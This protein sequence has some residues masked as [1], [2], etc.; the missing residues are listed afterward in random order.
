MW[1]W[2]A[3]ARAPLEASGGRRG[4]GHQRRARRLPAYWLLRWS[5]SRLEQPCRPPL[6]RLACAPLR[7][8]GRGRRRASGRGALV[9]LF[10]ILQN[11]GNSNHALHEAARALQGVPRSPRSEGHSRPERGACG[12]SLRAYTAGAVLQ[13]AMMNAAGQGKHRAQSSRGGAVPLAPASGHRMPASEHHAP[14]A[15]KSLGMGQ[16]QN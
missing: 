5:A 13:A 15:W 10:A 12:L 11:A 1:P 2:W 14:A 7:V 8:A 9:S 3:L 4:R 6:H 16:H